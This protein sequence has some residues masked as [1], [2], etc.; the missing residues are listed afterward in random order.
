MQ[1][2][3][4]HQHAVMNLSALK[5]GVNVCQELLVVY[6]L[7]TELKFATKWALTFLS[8]SDLNSENTNP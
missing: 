5:A 8:H 2:T 1:P 3:G 4:E 6:K 7:Q